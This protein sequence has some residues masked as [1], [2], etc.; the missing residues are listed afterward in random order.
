MPQLVSSTRLDGKNCSGFM[1]RCE[2]CA[3]V[4]FS[5]LLSCLTSFCLLGCVLLSWEGWPSSCLLLHVLC[6]LFLC[7]Q[8]ELTLFLKQLL[9]LRKYQCVFLT[10]HARGDDAS[11]YNFTHSL[12]KI[13]PKPQADG[14]VDNASLQ[15]FWRNDALSLWALQV[16]K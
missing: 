7:K 11:K 3:R 5:S 15:T 10:T 6:F 4:L 13:P 9:S 16:A 1:E 8:E 12:L 14:K 2:A